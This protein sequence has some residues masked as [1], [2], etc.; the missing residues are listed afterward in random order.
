MD[1]MKKLAFSTL[2]CPAWS[3]EKVVENAVKM[4]FSAIEIR[5]IEDELD[6]AKVKCFLPENRAKT[7]ALLKENNLVIS[8]LGTS[9]SFHDPAGHPAAIAEC[10]AALEICNDMGIMGIR[11]FGNNFIEGVD[12]EQTIKDV[13]NGIKAVCDEAEKMGS[14]KVLLEI[15]GDFNTVENVGKLLKEIGDKPSF[16]IIWDIIHSYHASRN[17]FVPFYELIKPYIMHVHTKDCIIENDEIID[18]LPG[19]GDIDMPAMIGAME[20]DGYA[21]YYSL[22]WEKRWRGELPEPEEVFPVYVEYMRTL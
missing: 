11:V 4:G 18:L 13:A 10:V 3:F 9:A 16:G 8:D 6:N 12:H 5:G 19:K 15:H 17:D 21:G 2:G 20:K 14:A 7:Q 1:V 22:E